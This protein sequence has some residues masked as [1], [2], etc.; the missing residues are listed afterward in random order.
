MTNLKLGRLL[1][2]GISPGFLAYVYFEG[3]R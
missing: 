1:D 3:A 2:R